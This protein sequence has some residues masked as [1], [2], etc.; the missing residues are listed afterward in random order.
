MTIE[1]T[2]PR[3]SE[4]RQKVAVSAML[5]LALL[6]CAWI[7]GRWLAQQAVPG[8]AG[9][10]LAKH[11]A[12]ALNFRAALAEGQLLPRLQPYGELGDV[13]VFQYY[14]FFEG[15]AAWPFL[16]LGLT[17]LHAVA[18]AIVLLRWAAFVVVYLT[19]RTL[20]AGPAASALA[21]FAYVLSPYL[22][23][24]ELSRVAIAEVHAH[25]LLPVC[26]LGWA[27]LRS[28]PAL[29]TVLIALGVAAL[30]LAHNIFFLYTA[31]LLAILFLCSL[32]DWR[33]SAGVALGTTA[34][35]LL[36]GPQWY[37]AYASQGDLALN[38]LDRSLPYLSARYVSLS[39]LWGWLHP[40][41]QAIGHASLSYYFTFAWWTIPSMAGLVWVAVCRPERRPV[42][43]ALLAVGAV[44]GLLVVPPVDFWTVLPTAFAAVQFGYRLIAYVALISALGL[45]VTFPKLPWAVLGAL[46]PVMVFSQWPAIHAD[47]HSFD[48]VQLTDEQ[49]ATAF[50]SYDYISLSAPKPPPIELVH[51]DKMLQKQNHLRLRFGPDHGL[52]PVLQLAGYNESAESL[53]LRLMPIN[54]AGQEIPA[55]TLSEASI[56]AGAFSVALPLDVAWPDQRIVCL[57][58]DPAATLAGSSA[59]PL[60]LRSALQNKESDDLL[61][62]ADGLEEVARYGYRREWKVLPERVRDFAPSSDSGYSAYI[63][64]MPVAYNRF[65]EVVHDGRNVDTFSDSF[66]HLCVKLARP[67]GT[68][69][70]RYRMPG[71]GWVMFGAGLLLCGCQPWLGALR[72]TYVKAMQ[73]AKRVV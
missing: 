28:R 11:V 5:F 63:F 17:G 43:V 44:F 61:L 56:P 51:T 33:A 42:S 30:A 65:W 52:K 24:N 47:T 2:D 57:P 36:A 70:L 20:Q 9:Q 58:P 7:N 12:M 14:G 68:L 27:L 16:A 41:R 22:I 29:G 60:R 38:F 26:L 35:V 25:S 64:Q 67:G 48:E 54:A 8:S 45:A 49:I 66:C 53:T 1:P 55:S 69:T 40:Y 19:G 4:R 72:M 62:P 73:R 3:A 6:L 34:G 37:P 21:G 32:P 46:L 10:D 31:V 39:G 59:Y 15:L 71:I 13:P 23:T 50:A 18:A